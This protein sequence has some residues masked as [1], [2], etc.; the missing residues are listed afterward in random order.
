MC[1]LHAG[2]PGNKRCMVLERVGSCSTDAH[3]AS[4]VYGAGTCRKLDV[5]GPYKQVLDVNMY[6]YKI[7]VCMYA[8]VY[9]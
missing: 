9:A 4:Y 7:L 2:S 1:G 5:P 6:E 3:T 8:H